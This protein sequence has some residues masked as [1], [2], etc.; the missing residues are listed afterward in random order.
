MQHG[1]KRARLK[2]ENGER[3]SERTH[4]LEQQVEALKDE[5]AES[6]ELCGALRAAAESAFAA[7]SR[8]SGEVIDLI[9]S[10]PPSALP[11][12]VAIECAVCAKRRK[13]RRASAASGKK[14]ARLTK[15]STDSSNAV[16]S[17]NGEGDELPREVSLVSSSPVVGEPGAASA[18]VSVNANDEAAVAESGNPRTH[19]DDQAASEVDTVESL[20]A[21]VDMLRE[22]LRLEQERR[23]QVEWAVNDLR[24]QRAHERALEM[25]PVVREL[26]AKGKTASDDALVANDDSPVLRPRKHAVPAVPYS[27]GL[28][29]ATLRDAR[30]LHQRVRTRLIL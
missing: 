21:E 9:L 5:L 29:L 11:E 6:N 3:T 23:E 27:P 19:D 22:E 24:A 26:D 16:F 13:A 4:Q 10:R 12:G 15:L 28:R 18:S 30:A 14:P 20:Q 7:A 8:E 1:G 17:K 2:A 25:S